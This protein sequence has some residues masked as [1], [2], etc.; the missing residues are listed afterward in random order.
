M[1][2][3]YVCPTAETFKTQNNVILSSGFGTD[4]GEEDLDW[5]LREIDDPLLSLRRK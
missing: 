5:R 4:P 1:K 2:K 3:L